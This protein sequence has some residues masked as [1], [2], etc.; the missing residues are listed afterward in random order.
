MTVP[1]GGDDSNYQPQIGWQMVL[2][3]LM[4]VNNGEYWFAITLI[5]CIT[6]PDYHIVQP[7]PDFGVEN[8]WLVPTSFPLRIMEMRGLW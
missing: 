5:T 1:K 8:T 7:F 2:E 3:W 6:Q 4:I